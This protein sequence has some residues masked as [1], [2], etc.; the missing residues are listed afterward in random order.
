MTPSLGDIF[1]RPLGDRVTPIDKDLF[2]YEISPKVIVNRWKAKFSRDFSDILS[3]LVDLEGL[4]PGIPAS[5]PGLYQD[6]SFPARRPCWTSSWTW[7]NATA[8]TG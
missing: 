3:Q 4:D 6:R 8:S 2:G 7:W 5:A 1:G